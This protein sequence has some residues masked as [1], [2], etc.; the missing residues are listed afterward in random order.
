MYRLRLTLG[1]DTTISKTWLRIGC[2]RNFRSVLCLK[3]FTFPY[4]TPPSVVNFLLIFPAETVSLL[5]HTE[6]L[7]DLLQQQKLGL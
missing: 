3:V 2:A 5:L 1:L 7:S 4:D 6:S